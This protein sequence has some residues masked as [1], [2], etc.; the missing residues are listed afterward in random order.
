MGQLGMI[1]NSVTLKGMGD[2]KQAGCPRL[3]HLQAYPRIG[4]KVGG[5]QHPPEY[6]KTETIQQSM[7]GRGLAPAGTCEIKIWKWEV[8]PWWENMENSPTKL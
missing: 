1:Q 2:W 3:P 8:F 7:L 4:C 6:T 5:S